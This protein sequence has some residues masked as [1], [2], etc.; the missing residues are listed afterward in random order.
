MIDAFRNLYKKYGYYYNCIGNFGFE[1]A[2][3]MEKMAE[4]MARTRGNA[5]KEIGGLKVL[6]FS[7]Y[8]VSKT[9]DL[10]SGKET[11][12]TLPNSDVLVFG[13]EGGA[14]VIIRPSGTEPKI[15]VYYTTTGLSLIHI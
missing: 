7:D 13:L 10:V 11:E 8:K 6:E 9:I 2:A 5:P 4:I 3:G 14:S 15:K 12:I 1:G